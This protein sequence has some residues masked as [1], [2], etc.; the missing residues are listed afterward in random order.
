MHAKPYP[1]GTFHDCANCS[2]KMLAGEPRKIDGWLDNEKDYIGSI[3][4]LPDQETADNSISE[5]YRPAERYVVFK[6]GAGCDIK[7]RD[8]DDNFTIYPVWFCGECERR[9]KDLDKAGACCE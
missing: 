1:P 4:E 8:H 2:N 7:P 9:Y 6:C 3:V 5:E